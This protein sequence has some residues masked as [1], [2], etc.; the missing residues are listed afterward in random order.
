MKC[1]IMVKQRRG[2]AQIGSALPW[3]GRGRGFKSRYS[4]QI[5]T[6]ILLYGCYYLLVRIPPV[7]AENWMQSPNVVAKPQ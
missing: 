5:I 2:M 6:A 4:D 3:G 1:A 7:F